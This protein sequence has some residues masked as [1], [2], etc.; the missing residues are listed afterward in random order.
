MLLKWLRSLIGV[1]ETPTEA[2]LWDMC[3]LEITVID[4][5]RVTGSLVQSGGVWRVGDY[6]IDLKRI[7]VIGDKT[8][9]MVH[10]GGEYAA[11]REAAWGHQ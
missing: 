6:V 11:G 8:I 5:R 7:D 10:S 9:R 4:E 2:H 3:G 1:S